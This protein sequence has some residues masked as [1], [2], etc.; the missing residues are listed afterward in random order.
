MHRFFRALL[1]LAFSASLS[2]SADAQDITTNL[3]AHW[4]LVETSGVTAVD[5]S[6]TPN[7]GVYTNGVVLA[8]S[9]PVPSDSAV[10]ARFDGVNDYV[11]I[12]NEATYDYTGAMTVAVWIKVNAFTVSE[13][14]IVTKGDTA[15]RLQ[16]DTTTNGVVFTCRGLTTNRIASPANVN[17]GQWHHVVG[18]YTGGQLRIYVD[19]LLS[20]SVG[21]FGFISTNG[22]PVEIGR[23]AEAVGKEFNGWIYDV[24]LYNRALSAADVS[25]LYLQGGP[26][27][28]WTLAETSGATA[29]DSSL[30]DAN[31]TVS[32][33]AGWST[34]CT[35]VGALN[36]DGSTNY[37]SIP[38][39]PQLQP[40]AT[41]TLAAWVRGDSWGVA[42]DVDAILR[43]GEANPNNY[44]FSIVDGRVALFLDDSDTGG[45]RGNT[46]L[47][48]G[49]WHHVAATW[50]GANVRIYVNGQ[51]DNTPTARTGTIGA[52]ARPL[53]IGGYSGSDQFDGLVRDA[54]LYCRALSASE[55]VRLYG[56]I[57]HWKFAEGAGTAAADSSGLVNNATLSGGA[58]W[59]T[60][61]AGNNN[62]LLTNGAGGIAQ[63]ASAFTPPS[64]GTV[65][66]WMRSNGVPPALGRVFGVGGDWEARQMTN[67]I[68][69]FDLCGE[70]GGHFETTTPLDEVGRWYHVAATF[71]SATDAYAIY[72]D[73]QLH[74]SGTNA[75]AMLQRPAAVL[76]FG[77]RTGVAEYWQGALRD[78]RIYNRLLCPSEIAELYG[79]VGHWK[80]D[81]S[82]GSIA[83]DSSGLGRSGT[84]IGTAA[85]TAGGMVG[86]CLQLNGAT[87]IEVNSLMDSPKNAT[88]SAWASLAARDSSG[89]ELVSLGDY[90]FIRLDQGGATTS[91]CFYNGTTWISVPV[92]QTFVGAGWHHFAAV[93]NDDQNYCKLYIDGVEAA[94]LSTTVT[95][96]FTGLG[97]KTLIG[98]HGNGGTTWDFTGRVDDVRVYNRPLCPADIQALHAMGSGGYS[99]VR[100]ISWVETR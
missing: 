83:A 10:A 88:L 29:A 11:A 55:I 39:A 2:A 48:T 75:N 41:L 18:V 53:Y 57:G 30:Y 44:Q 17:D 34:L 54:R 16:R 36:F 3:R 58:A 84:V 4:K 47:A 26:V 49:Q 86:N 37:V 95:L 51:L 9:T 68:L 71:D 20:N 27:G 32:G 91:A 43:K 35:G 78:F 24:R 77:T 13:Q 6:P 66:F 76:S 63:T 7:N 46:V 14:A 45:V 23:N 79:L 64:V 38:N 28:H 93:F 19:G 33:A 56:F 69:V 99:G 22:F 81:E 25:Y 5:S 52:D 80:L 98:A 60:D 12:P 85:W 94:S 90:F 59:T 42:G 100:I 21:S 61:C 50:D 40:T 70:G 8:N 74:K 73:G 62:A 92:S 97:T 1:A 72:I 15:W 67:G 31:G 89:A 87:R 96:P 65:A 82:S